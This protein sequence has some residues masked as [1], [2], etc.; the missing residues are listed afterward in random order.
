MLSRVHNRNVRKVP[1]AALQL[2]LAHEEGRGVLANC[3]Q[4]IRYIRV[5]LTERSDWSLVV[6]SA[7]RDFDR[8]ALRLQPSHCCFQVRCG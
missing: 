4:A 8:G 7:V 5:V 2:A 6:T 1:R 3:T